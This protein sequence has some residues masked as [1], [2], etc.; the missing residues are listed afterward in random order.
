MAPG[1][2]RR[3]Q[4]LVRSVHIRASIL[5]K[6]YHGCRCMPPHRTHLLLRTLPIVVIAASMGGLEALL[7][8]FLSMPADFRAAVLV[9]LHTSPTG[10]GLAA[11]LLDSKVAMRVSYAHSGESPNAGHIYLA[12][13]DHHL[14]LAADGRMSLNK[15]TKVHHSRPAANPL[16]ESA[17]AVYGS[18]VIGVVLTGGDSDGADGLRLITSAGGVGV[19]QC[20]SEAYDPSMPEAAMREDH[21]QYILPVEEIGPLLLKLISTD[22]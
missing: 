7:Q 19:V 16:F 21:P 11:G 13:P 18:Q 17:V 10:P 6:R 2:N 4:L 22:C 5:V 12:P 14:I 9:V 1:N 15:K 20:P 8:L 3:R